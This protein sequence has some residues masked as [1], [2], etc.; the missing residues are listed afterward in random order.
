MAKA[1]LYEFADLLFCAE[2]IGYGWNDAHKI[3]VDDEVP[4]MYERKTSEFYKSECTPEAN[5][6]YYGYS[7]DT[8][9]ILNAFFEQEKIDG[10]TL[11]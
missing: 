9:K 1:D 7:E 4:P 5:A 8:L 3:L 2:K 11:V 6:T 10:F